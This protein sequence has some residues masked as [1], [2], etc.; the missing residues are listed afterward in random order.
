MG[1]NASIPSSEIPKASSKSKEESELNYEIVA[2]PKQ[3]SHA[4]FLY[5]QEGDEI[6]KLLAELDRRSTIEPS[7]FSSRL[8]AARKTKMGQSALLVPTEGWLLKKSPNFFG[9]W[10]VCFLVIYMAAKI[11]CSF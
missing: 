10:N 5:A 3:Q 9:G 7:L 11:L 4:P 8:T 6:D 1:S 2:P